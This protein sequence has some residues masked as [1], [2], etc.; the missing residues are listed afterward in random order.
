MLTEASVPVELESYE[1]MNAVNQPCQD[2]ELLDE[3]ELPEELPTGT[4]VQ[5]VPSE[6]V[7]VL[8]LSLPDEPLSDGAPGQVYP[9]ALPDELSPDE[10][11]GQ[12]PPLEPVNDGTPLEAGSP[13]PPDEV[14]GPLSALPVSPPLP[15]LPPLQP[16]LRSAHKVSHESRRPRKS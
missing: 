2:C 15:P 1:L 8:P 6:E 5:V 16:S 9:P 12:V 13:A 14:P 3:D 10:L 4:T 7:H 11:L